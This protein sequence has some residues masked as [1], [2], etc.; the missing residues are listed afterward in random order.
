MAKLFKDIESREVQILSQEYRKIIF[1]NLPDDRRSEDNHFR[2]V[3]LEYKTNE[4]GYSYQILFNSTA[5]LTNNFYW[6]FVYKPDESVLFYSGIKSKTDYPPVWDRGF[7]GMDWFDYEILIDQMN[8][9]MAENGLNKFPVDTIHD[10]KWVY[11]VTQPVDEVLKLIEE[12]KSYDILA[13][14]APAFFANTALPKKLEPE[15]E[16]DKISL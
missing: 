13:L 10:D 7:G 6:F 14:K 12:G 8:R 3:L 5:H 1:P 9:G 16:I 11:L 2:F 4:D 15:L